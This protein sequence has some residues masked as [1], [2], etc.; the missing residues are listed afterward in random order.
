MI[1][2]LLDV[3]LHQLPWTTVGLIELTPVNGSATESYLV[4]CFAAV[5][6]LP[7]FLLCLHEKVDDKTMIIKSH[8]DESERKKLAHDPR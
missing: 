3:T 6:K 8:V 5:E 4:V 1:V 2:S 7:F